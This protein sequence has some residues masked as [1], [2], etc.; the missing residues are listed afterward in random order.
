[1]LAKGTPI[2]IISIPLLSMVSLMFYFWLGYSYF[3]LLASVLLVLFLPVMAFFRDPER[4]IGEGVVSPADGRIRDIRMDGGRLFISIFMNVHNVHVNRMPFDGRILSVEHLD[5]GYLPAFK[6]DS[7]RNERVLIV[8]STVNG[9]WE[10]KQIAGSV[11]RRIVTY[12]GPGDLL[13]KGDRFGLIRF[14]SR[15]DLDLKVPKG[16]RLLVE[17]GDR[18]FAGRTSLT[19]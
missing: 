7:D 12:A 3:I 5:G 17:V 19:R 9:K 4:P 14:G 1:M 15:V 13:R 10:M 2:W 18:V 8:F 16:H 6:K 11:A